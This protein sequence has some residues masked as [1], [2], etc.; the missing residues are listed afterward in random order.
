LTKAD[1]VREA[2]ARGGN[3]GDTV[4]IHDKLGIPAYALGR[5]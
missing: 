4:S 5:S 3:Y 1:D 2:W